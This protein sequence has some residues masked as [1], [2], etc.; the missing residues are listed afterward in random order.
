MPSLE[1]KV[2]VITGGTS[3]IGA[4]IAELF[5]AEG[6][7]VVIAG[8]RRDRGE[9][10]AAALGG[11]ALFVRTDVSVEADVKEMI[12]KAVG[13]CGRLD[14]LI[15]NAGTGSKH[16]GLAEVDL[17]EFDATIAVHVRGALAAM[18]YAAP[19]MAAQKSGSIITVASINGTRAGLGCNPDHPRCRPGYHG[20]CRAVLLIC[21]G[22]QVAAA[23]LMALGSL[24]VALPRRSQ[25]GRAMS[26]GS[27]H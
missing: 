23:G 8:R 1:G 5:V 11:A 13:R 19:V 9:R 20:G 4:R 10:L 3:G 22:L 26:H 18:K 6:A 14:C 17:E 25:P 27:G 16:V 15:N 12:E 2:A 7:C 24:L 21:L